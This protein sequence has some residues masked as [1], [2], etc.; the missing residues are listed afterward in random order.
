MICSNAAIKS[1]IAEADAPL[2]IGFKYGRAD[3][4][5]ANCPAD[6]AARLPDESKSTDHVEDVFVTRMGFS[7]KETVALMGAHRCQLPATSCCTLCCYCVCSLWLL[8]RGSSHCLR[9]CFLLSLCVCVVVW[10]RWSPLTPG[11]LASG[12]ARSPKW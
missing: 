3:V 7:K 1:S 11:M 4:E 6:I 8:C 9:L 2:T 5:C 10:A 12:T